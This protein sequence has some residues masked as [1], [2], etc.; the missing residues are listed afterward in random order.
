MTYTNELRE[1]QGVQ[2]ETYLFAKH[3]LASSAHNFPQVTNS[4]FKDYL[5]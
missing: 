3:K 2:F 1:K 5:I 4:R